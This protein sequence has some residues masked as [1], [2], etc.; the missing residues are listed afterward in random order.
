MQ[1]RL[2]T[3][4]ALLAFL[5]PMVIVAYDSFTE[6]PIED[7]PQPGAGG[8]IVISDQPILYPV[9]TWR[10]GDDIIPYP[11]PA[12]DRPSL[13]CDDGS[14]YS[15]LF[16]RFMFYEVEFACGNLEKTG[17]SFSQSNH[18]WT[19]VTDNTGKRYPYDWGFYIP[20]EQHFEYYP[21]SYR[22]ILENSVIKDPL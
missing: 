3:A 5:I 2:Q 13:D 19:V 22:Y 20:D 21:K 15:Y 8:N 17:E 16:M 1:Y 9:W 12:R 14:V 10:L 11:F 7:Y 4:L 6:K 18:Y